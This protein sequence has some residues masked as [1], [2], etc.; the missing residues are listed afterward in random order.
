MNFLKMILASVIGYII[1][2]LVVFGILIAIVVGVAAS[3]TP[4]QPEIRNESVLNLRLN[5]ELKDRF[6]DNNPFAALSALDPNVP[7]PVGLVDILRAIENAKEDDDIKGIVLDLTSLESG[8]GKLSEIR[9]KLKEFKES[10]KFVYA[11]ADYYMYKSYYIASVA[12]SVFVNPEGQMLFN[13][14]VAEV[15]FFANTLEKLGVEMQVVRHGKFKGAVEPFT[16]TSLSP[17][18]K[19]QISAYINSVYDATLS[20]IAASRGLTVEQ[21]KADANTL[22]MRKVEDFVSKHY[23]DMMAY[24]DQFYKIMKH[25]MGLAEDDKVELVSVNKYKRLSSSYK[26]ADNEIAVV[27]ATGDIINGKGDGT[28]I[29]ADD[30]AATLKKLREDE[31]V[32][33]V[34]L[35]IDSRGGS[36][37]ASDIIWREAKLLAET[38]TLIVSMSDYA[39]SGGYY[40][41]SPA[42]KIVADATTITGSIGVFGLVPNAQKLLNDKLGV[43]FEYVGTNEYSD[44]GRVDRPLKAE[45][46]AYIEAFIDDIY[47]EFVSK[48]SEGRSLT[49][50]QVDSIAQGRVWTGIMAK[51]VGLVDEIGGLEKAIELAAAQAALEDYKVRDYPKFKD[52][53]EMIVDRMQGKTSMESQL[54]NTPVGK[55]IKTF[56]DAEQLG[57]KHSVQMRMPFDISVRNY[58]LR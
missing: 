49:P 17:E 15:S 12:D 19:A 33:A 41:A 45:E 46:R 11:Y 5:Y 58:E 23:L 26:H 51:E 24:K 56:I 14:M 28:Q 10:G 54:S 39:A 34:V 29:A 3:V 18:N 52:P 2:A 20:E 50:A 32:K 47:D 30:L 25:R 57:T 31:D 44:M 53:V 13:G 21:L 1:A 43:N 40:I 22:E 48:V 8:Y 27:Y 35:R 36:A 37:L 16:R 4:K 9:E 6:Q 42:H 55:Y 7:I 38:K